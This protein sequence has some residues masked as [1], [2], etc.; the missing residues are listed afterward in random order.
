[1]KEYKVTIK[2]FNH[3]GFLPDFFGKTEEIYIKADSVEELRQSIEDMIKDKFS[4][5]TEMGE[6]T[7]KVK[8]E[9]V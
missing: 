4:M 8:I 3:A 1:M 5:E 6:M 2:F 7:Y 9:L